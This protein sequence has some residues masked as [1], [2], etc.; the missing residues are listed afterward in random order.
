[1][2]YQYQ[3]RECPFCGWE[4]NEGDMLA[5]HIESLHAEDPD[6]DQ[7]PYSASEKAQASAF[8]EEEEGQY[9]E[10]PIEGCGEILMLEEMDYHLELHEQEVDDVGGEASAQVTQKTDQDAEGSR[11]GPSSSRRQSSSGRSSSAQQR[12]DA[13]RSYGS[14]SNSSKQQTAISAWR[15]IFNMPSSSRRLTEAEKRVAASAVPG[16]RLGRSHLGKYAHEDRMPDWLI[17]LLQKHGQVDQPGIIPVLQQ[18]LQQSSTT[19][20]AYLCHPC[21]HH[22][23][24]LRRE[25]GFCGYRTIQMMTSYLIG[26]ASAGNQHFKPKAQVPSIFQIQD[27]IEA[28]WDAGINSQGRAETGGV[29]MT[30]K[31]IGTLE[32]SAVF[33]LL[34]IPCETQGFRNPEPGRSETLLLEEV[35]NYFASG[36]VDPEERIRGTGLPPIFFQHPGHSMLIVGFEKQ[37]DGARN[38][39]VFDSMFSDHWSVRKLVRKESSH[40]LPDMALKP[41]R[42]GSRYLG[43]YKAF[44]VLRF[45]LPTDA[46]PEK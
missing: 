3:V 25:G 35:E 46:I 33:R 38:L 10:C 32:A 41:Y 9:V 26:T 13:P 14:S 24:R 28:A 4:A 16:K 5:L 40:Y 21:V 6:P 7:Q 17:N 43:K 18:L 12:E 45:R 20:Y 39:L 44:E 30:R 42:R 36:V 34:E 1:M 2:D 15:N 8:R 19:K 22:I 31:Y 11:P 29:K 37:K 23:S 27:W